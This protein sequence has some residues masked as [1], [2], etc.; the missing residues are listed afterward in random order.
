MKTK[1]IKLLIIFG[2]LVQNLFFFVVTYLNFNSLRGTDYD[3][4]GKYL[5]YFVKNNYESIGLES[6]VSYFW[7]ISKIFELLKTPLLISPIYVEPVYSFSIQLGNFIFYSIGLFG[8]YYLFQYL[9]IEDHKNLI[10][11]SIISIFPPLIGARIILKP[12]IMVFAFLPWLVFIY[13]RYFDE[14]KK[15]FLILSIPL[16]STLLVLKSSISLM[17]VLSLLVIFN[18]KIFEK[19]FL[20]FNLMVLPVLYLLIMESFQVNGNFLW[21]HKV[22]SNYNNKAGLSYLLNIDFKELINNPFRNNLKNSM[23]SILFADTF[24]DYWQR[25]WYHKDGWSGN[26]YPGNLVFI[27]SSIVLSIIFY[28]GI[29]FFLFKSKLKELKVFGL[30]VYVGIVCLIINAVNLFPFLTMNFDPSKGDPMKTHLFSFLIVFSFYFFLSSLLKDTKTATDLII[31]LLFNIYIFS[32]LN[33]VSYTE[34]KNSSFYLNKIHVAVPC[35]LNEVANKLIN[36]DDNW[37]GEENLAESICKGEH[38]ELMIPKEQD[39]YLIYENDPSFENRNLTNGKKTITVG[40]YFECKSY[41]IGGYYSQTF[42]EFTG[43]VVEKPLYL[44]KL[45][46]YLSFFIIFY[47]FIFIVRQKVFKINTY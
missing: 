5:D 20:M 29:F 40:N 19:N 31:L 14:K 8:L 35:S 15:Y 6:G 46:L 25:Y 36:Y 38:D 3:R 17:V 4:Y 43:S 44:S 39:G 10:I 2:V 37:C 1:K 34:I 9:K 21:E 22:N 28:F 32:M 24:N 13:Y 16:I 33:P 30:L 45:T 11:L 26:N 41:V 42:D 18:K 23:I 27:R 47:I 7:F 12:E